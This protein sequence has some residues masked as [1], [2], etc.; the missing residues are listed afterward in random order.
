MA[1]PE[2]GNRDRGMASLAQK[3]VISTAATASTYRVVGQQGIHV[4]LGEKGICKHQ[5]PP[6]GH[7]AVVST[8][9][10]WGPSPRDA[11]MLSG[12]VWGCL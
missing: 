8:Q 1:A 12:M 2:A 10:V 4:V 11:P 6:C 5:E 9:T 3:G 7:P